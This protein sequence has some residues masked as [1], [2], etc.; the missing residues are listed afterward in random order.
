MNKT[1]VLSIIENAVLFD[2][3]TKSGYAAKELNQNKFEFIGDKIIK[4]TEGYK[5]YTYIEVG[6]IDRIKTKEV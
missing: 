2:I 1:N 4:I 6:S 5:T 3:H